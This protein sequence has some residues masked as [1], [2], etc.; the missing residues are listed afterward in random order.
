MNK[1]Y[2]VGDT[3]Y[4]HLFGDTSCAGTGIFKGWGE[5][6]MMIIELSNDLPPFPAKT[7]ISVKESEIVE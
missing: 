5:E 4:F 3:L 1:Q 2:N 6:E 7:L